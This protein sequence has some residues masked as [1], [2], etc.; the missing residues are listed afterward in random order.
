MSSHMSAGRA[1]EMGYRNVHVMR[2]GIKEWA[3]RGFP[4]VR[5]T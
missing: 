2:G 5:G 3:N 1:Q 4:L